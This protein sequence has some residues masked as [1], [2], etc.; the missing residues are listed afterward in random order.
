MGESGQVVVVPGAGS[1]KDVFEERGMV[2]R[3]DDEVLTA[4]YY[5]VDMEATEGGRIFAEQSASMYSH[6]YDCATFLKSLVWAV[7]CFG[8]IPCWPPPIHI[9]KYKHP[10]RSS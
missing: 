10:L 1:V 5:S 7:Y 2:F 6:I 9:H 3:H 4:S 8:S